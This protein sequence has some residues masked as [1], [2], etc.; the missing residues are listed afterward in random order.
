MTGAYAETTFPFRISAGAMAFITLLPTTDT[1]KTE[2][3]L[4]LRPRVQ[5]N[6]R[7]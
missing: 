2:V 1:D 3:P 6:T 7:V 4:P 5:P